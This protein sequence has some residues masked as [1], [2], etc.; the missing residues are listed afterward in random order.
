MKKTI[1]SLTILL[2]ILLLTSGCGKIPVL[3]NGEEAVLEINENLISTE[4]FYKEIKEKYGVD[5][6]V[7]LI[8]KTILDEKYPTDEDETSYIDEQINSLKS[9]A[10]Q[11]G[12]TYEYILSYYGFDNENDAKEYLSLNY[13]RQLAVE[14]YVESTIKEKEINNYYKNSI[15]GDIN[16]KH[17]LIQPETADGM[18]EDE[19][20][21]A[22]AEALKK[23][24]EVIKKLNDGA[25]W[26]DL[27]KE[28]STDD[29]TKDSNGDLGWFNTGEMVKE[30]ETAAYALK[31]GKYSTT[32][33]E[34]S[35][36]YHI[37]YKTD[38]KEKPALED[39]KNDIIDTLVAEKLEEDTTLQYKGL[40]K[41]REDAGLEIHDSELKKAYKDYIN[42]LY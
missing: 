16:A 2:G 27:V 40:E 32:P 9:S 5:V 15:K 38:E 3:Q 26:D 20:K 28:Y 13:K 34:S 25:K 39:V 8:D 24:K 18:T 7:S 23:A 22:K 36:G 31:K 37:I 1:S 33:V 17:I 29:G 35:Y 41:L 4:T 42:S 11:N 30:F 21:K 14:D 19:T 12:V 10:E 6:L